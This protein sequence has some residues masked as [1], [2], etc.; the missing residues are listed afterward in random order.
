MS[1]PSALPT[2]TK[3]SYM[4]PLKLAVSDLQ[5]LCV[6]GTDHDMKFIRCVLCPRVPR[7]RLWFQA[8][9]GGP[10]SGALEVCATCKSLILFNLRQRRESDTIGQWLVVLAKRCLLM[11]DL[12]TLIATRPVGQR[13]RCHK[14]LEPALTTLCTEDICDFACTADLKYWVHYCAPCQVAFIRD[15]RAS[16]FHRKAAAVFPQAMTTHLLSAVPAELAHII[17]RLML[18]SIDLDEAAANSPEVT[19]WH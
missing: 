13:Y 3:T 11:Q 1:A 9:D 14:C 6:L 18:E 12:E 7:A 16:V 19:W 2:R 5:P 17:R 10:C 15:F 4:W 8:G